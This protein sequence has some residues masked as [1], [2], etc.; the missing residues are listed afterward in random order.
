MKQ[1]TLLIIINFLTFF[2]VNG[3][4]Y[5]IFDSISKM[6]NDSIKSIRLKTYMRKTFIGKKWED[7]HRCR[8]ELLKFSKKNKDSILY[9]KALEYSG[10]YFQ[11]YSER[12]DSA[13]Y[14]FTKSKHIYERLKDTSSMGRVLTNNAILR[15]NIHDYGGSIKTS[16]QALKYINPKKKKRIASVYNNL[17]IAFNQ[18]KDSTDA[19]KYH[20]K[21]L[22]LRNTLT[23][24]P[25]LK[26]QSLNNIGKIYKDYGR[27][28][29][30]INYF[31]P[32][33]KDSLIKNK[34][35]KTYAMALDN[36]GH[37]LFLMNNNLD[38]VKMINKALEIRKQVS[39]KDGIVIN[40]I[41]LA[42][43][44]LKEKDTIKAIKL[45]DSANIIA[46][47]I[48]NYRDYLKSMKFLAEVY[49]GKVSK[50]LYK[51]HDHIKDSLFIADTRYRDRFDQFEFE[52][53]ERDQ[54]LESTKEKLILNR[55]ILLVIGILIISGTIIFSRNYYKTK[56]LKKQFEE[57]FREYLI[58]KYNLTYENIVFWETWILDI[59]TEDL[60]KKLFIS[61]DAVKSRKK[62]LRNKIYKI[63]SLEGNFTQSRAIRI[64]N[65]ELETFKN[66]G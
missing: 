10:S 53:N 60:A 46:K 16:F 20:L 65:E 21:S 26:A 56:K 22:Q 54:Q 15:K 4:S 28:K 36:Y 8:F 23:N 30:A 1:I 12:L 9:A 48:L 7:F 45:A 14:Y 58:D 64:Y 37:A 17:G 19:I 59:K 42:E 57:G 51:K 31:L 29:K 39:H 55:Y 13:F 11:V 34:Y 24:H 62:S 3:Q 63:S 33:V 43:Y 27:Y 38:G 5:N 6:Q 35:P 44:Y 52:K 40:K 61:G 50:N 32:V 47:E 66:Y 49:T 2:C 18:Q 41:H 25:N